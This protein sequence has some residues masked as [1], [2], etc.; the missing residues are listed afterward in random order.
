M[1]MVKLLF[2][3]KLKMMRSAEKK[4]TNC[5]FIVFSIF[6]C[7]S[8]NEINANLQKIKVIFIKRK[9]SLMLENK[10]LKMKYNIF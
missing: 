3:K 4:E 7:K 8:K 6:F 1:I 2:V 5:F 9:T 10:L